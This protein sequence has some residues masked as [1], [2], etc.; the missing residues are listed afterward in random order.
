LGQIDPRTYAEVRGILI[1][2]NYNLGAKSL[3]LS[4]FIA[5]PV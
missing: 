4:R 5:F 1:F 2:V 3:K